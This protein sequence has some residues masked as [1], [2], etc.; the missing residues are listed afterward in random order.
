MAFTLKFKQR[1]LL[2]NV[3]ITSQFSYAS[4]VWMFHSKK[5]NNQINHI[6][7]RTMRLVFKDYTSSFDELML[8][9]HS[10]RIHHRNLQK[11]TIEIFKVKSGIAP[12]ITKIFSNNQESV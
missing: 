7:E 6:H 2:L 12:E 4:V 3:F 1:N 8:K 11:F 10:F 9:D 5:L